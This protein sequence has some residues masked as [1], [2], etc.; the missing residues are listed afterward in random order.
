MEPDTKDW[1]WVL[2]RPCPDCGYEADA[3]APASLADRLVS[4]ADAWRDALRDPSATRRPDSV[5]WSCVEY[6]AHVRDVHR[7]FRERVALVLGHDDPEFEN[8]DQ[9]AEAVRGRYAQAR[10]EDVATELVAAAHEAA[11]LY[12]TAPG[13]AWSRSCRRSNGSRFTL[14]SLGRYHLHDVVH[15]LHDVGGTAPGAVRESAPTTGEAPGATR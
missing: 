13:D 9:D 6:G 2:E 10:P 12:A 1:T 8:W 5:T 4:N 3:V 7:V 11:Q 14:A 15:H